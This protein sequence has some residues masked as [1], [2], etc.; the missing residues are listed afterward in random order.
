MSSLGADFHFFIGSTGPRWN[1]GAEFLYNHMLS[2]YIKHTDKY[3]E[4]VFAGA[5][6]GWYKNTAANIRM[7]AMVNYRVKKFD[8]DLRAG[9]SATGKFNSY[10]FVPPLYANL[11]VSYRF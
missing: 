11:G 5:Q 8:I 9:Y 4:N 3:N 1:H 7:G 2:T 6:D 10:L